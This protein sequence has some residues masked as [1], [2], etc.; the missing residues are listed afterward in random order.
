MLTYRVNIKTSCGWE[1]ILRRYQGLG[2]RV[3][4]VGFRLQVRVQGLGW[5]ISHYQGSVSLCVYVCVC[6]SPCVYVCM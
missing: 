6:M 1:P 3:R 4:S 5:L 2:F